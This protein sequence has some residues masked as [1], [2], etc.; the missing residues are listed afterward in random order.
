MSRFKGCRLVIGAKSAQ[1]VSSALAYLVRTC[2]P[3]CAPL[4]LSHDPVLLLVCHTPVDHHPPDFP[5]VIRQLPEII[6]LIGSNGCWYRPHRSST[7]LF[8]ST[9]AVDPDPP[10]GRMGNCIPFQLDGAADLVVRSP[11][12]LAGDLRGPG[13]PVGGRLERVDT[14]PSVLICRSAAIAISTPLVD[15]AGSDS[16]GPRTP[17]V[18]VRK[19]LEPKSDGP[20]SADDEAW[21]AGTP[22]P[23]TKEASP[24][25]R[26]L[27]FAHLGSPTSTVYSPTLPGNCTSPAR[28]VMPPTEAGLGHPTAAGS[29]CLGAQISGP[30]AGQE[31]SGFSSGSILASWPRT[32]HAVPAGLT[33]H[34]ESPIL[35]LTTSLTDLVAPGNLQSSRPDAT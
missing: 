3:S 13:S 33:P 21:P 30:V 18:F 9:A 1:S 14:E 17:R 28:L 32:A 5:C 20:S 11:R 24:E 7:F 10:T 23:W 34:E 8:C 29:S 16:H 15:P 6:A 12:L 35:E 2:L 19:L 25:A 22:C 26:E 4:L 31:D 27:G